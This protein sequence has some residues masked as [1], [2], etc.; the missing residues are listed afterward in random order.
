MAAPSDL[1]PLELSFPLPSTE[2][3]RFDLNPKLF[4]LLILRALSSLYTAA[5]SGGST[6]VTPHF[7]LL[8]ASASQTIPSGARG[9]TV[10]FLTGT[11]TIGTR[12]VPAGFSDS[13]EQTLAASI[14]VTT[15]AASSGYVRWNT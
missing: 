14:A 6:P 7:V 15:D 10:T 5:T 1:D 8:G 9:W 4:M 11:G 2:A 3:R 13:S 12:A